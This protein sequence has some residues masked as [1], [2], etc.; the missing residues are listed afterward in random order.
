V[1]RNPNATVKD[2]SLCS[3][4]LRA[5]LLLPNK[6]WTSLATCSPLNL[7]FQFDPLVSPAHPPCGSTC[8]IYPWRGFNTII[9]LIMEVS[10]FAEIQEEFISRIQK[11][12]YCNMA[13]VDLKGWP[14]SRIMH[15][16]W[17]GHIG[18]VISWPETL[19]SKHI[20]EHISKI[21]SD[22]DNDTS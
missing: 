19:K 8:W 13:T 16:I 1:R 14:R 17:D 20:L 9:K 15:P 10:T 11:M 2:F 18:W 22:K 12:V 5:V 21:V 3:I 4:K 7:N 6:G